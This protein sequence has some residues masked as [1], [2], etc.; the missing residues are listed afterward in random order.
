M[1]TDLKL[2]LVIQGPLASTGN[3]GNGT[4]VK[5]FNCIDNINRIIADTH[6]LVDSFVLSTWHDDSGLFKALPPELKL[7]ELDD[8]GMDKSYLS[9][10]SNNEFRQAYGCLQGIRFA[11]DDTSPDYIIRVR[12][13]QY[14][15]IQG[16]LA[17]MLLIDANS[18]IYGSVGQEGYLYFPNMLSWSPYSVGD[19]YIGGHAHDVLRFFEAQVNLSRHSFTYA[20]S[21]IHSDLIL[22]HAYH[23][24]RGYL[25][26]PDSFYFPNIIPSLR[27]DSANPPW[28]LCYHPSVL[29]LLAQI[30]TRSICIFPRNIASS[31]EWRG[32]LNK[33]SSHSSGEFYTEWV[34]AQDDPIAWFIRQVP[35]L[36]LSNKP[37]SLMQKYLNFNHEKAT[38]IK[39]SRS[40]F[41]RHFHRS[42]RFLICIISASF[43]RYDWAICLW[44]LPRNL[45]NILLR[46][47]SRTL[48]LITYL[49]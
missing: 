34:E 44:L 16:M 5:D 22:R 29:T 21:W 26:L 38:E 19:F 17:H 2:A 24:L 31:M 13:D 32:N 35:Q 30:L 15:D 1:F 4:F 18:K 41:R 33:L 42:A 3:S 48:G 14:V 49:K 8:P 47:H 27:L 46:V 10:M 39:K 45:Y 25:E 9:G 23:N 12:T 7:V 43:P 40:V 36:Y 6:T 11:I 28:H 20:G 37:A